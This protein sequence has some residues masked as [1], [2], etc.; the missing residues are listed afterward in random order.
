MK[1]AVNKLFCEMDFF[2]TPPTLRSKNE[3]YSASLGLSVFSL[4]VLGLFIYL[5]IKGL[6]DC[7]NLDNSQMSISS[8]IVDIFLVSQ[9]NIKSQGIFPTSC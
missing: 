1:R 4:L 5:F 7:I 2:S 8:T 6:I 9:C 3:P